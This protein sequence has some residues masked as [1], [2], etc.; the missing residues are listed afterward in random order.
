VPWS[1]TLVANQ[2]SL[3]TR[4]M[5][6]PRAVE[7]HAWLQWKKGLVQCLSIDFTAS[8]IRAVSCDF[9]G[10]P[11]WMRRW[12]QYHLRQRVEP[13]LNTRVESSTHPLTRVVL[14]RE[15]ES[16]PTAGDPLTSVP[17]ASA[18]GTI[19]QYACREFDPRTYVGRT[20]KRDRVL[21]PQQAIH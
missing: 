1:F 18:G 3:P 11:A 12:G 10:P 4:K 8:S 20:D 6:W 2:R 15:I 17:P 14:T 5:P 13:S 21:A 16:S 7:L 9:V 19:C